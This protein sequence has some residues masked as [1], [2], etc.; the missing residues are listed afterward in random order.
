MCGASVDGAHG[1]GAFRKRTP[2]SGGEFRDLAVGFWIGE[3]EVG[4]GW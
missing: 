3:R 2:D 4:V 1:E